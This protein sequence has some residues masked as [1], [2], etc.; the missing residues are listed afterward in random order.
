MACIFYG[1]GAKNLNEPD[2]YSW[3]QYNDYYVKDSEF[4]SY[5]N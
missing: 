5:R 4:D 2:K 1:I 3:I